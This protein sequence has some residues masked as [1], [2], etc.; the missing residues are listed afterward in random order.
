VDLVVWFG[1]FCRP[2]VS[3]GVLVWCS[4]VISLAV[5]VFCFP[6]RARRRW[7][8]PWLVYR[9]LSKLG[10]LSVYVFGPAT[11]GFVLFVFIQIFLVFCFSC[12]YC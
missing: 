4:R 8:C 2:V 7:L 3:P 6:S 9:A 1:W 10:L 11:F 12:L 5:L